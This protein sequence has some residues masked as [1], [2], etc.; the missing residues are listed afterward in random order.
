MKFKSFLFL[1]IIFVLLLPIITFDD[2][3]TLETQRRSKK[4]TR[5]NKGKIITNSFKKYPAEYPVKKV[6]KKR[7]LDDDEDYDYD[8]DDNSEDIVF[9]YDRCD[10]GHTPDDLSDCTKYKTNS[11]ACCM[12]SYGDDSGCVLIGFHYLGSKTVG[13][14]KVECSQ[15]F[16]SK[17]LKVIFSLLLSLVLI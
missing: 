16:L 12:F 2:I 11:S 3:N 8:E 9:T 5:K 15:N 6:E 4:I 10:H 7:K 17:N 1:T 14:M 13:D